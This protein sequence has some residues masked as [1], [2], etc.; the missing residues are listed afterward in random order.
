MAQIRRNAIFNSRAVNEN[1]GCLRNQKHH[2]PLKW[3]V[4]LI[5]FHVISIICDATKSTI[6]CTF[7]CMR[8]DELCS[9]VE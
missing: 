6:L 8:S 9:A 5:V 2:S 7:E 1:R 3:N 4:F